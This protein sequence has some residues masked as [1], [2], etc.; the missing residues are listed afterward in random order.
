MARLARSLLSLL[1]LALSSCGSRS[2]FP[3]VPPAPGAA[4]PELVRETAQ[5]LE[6]DLTRSLLAGLAARDPELVA[7]AF[8]PG[9]LARLPGP[10]DG[11]LVA[12]PHFA[13][14][15]YET[16]VPHVSRRGKIVQRLLEHLGPW[17]AVE[18]AELTCS[19]LSLPAGG[20]GATWLALEL[21]LTG[22]RADG[23]PE[24]L[25]LAGVATARREDDR[26]CLERWDVQSGARVAGGATAF[27][28]VS[29]EVGFALSDDPALAALRR[30][31]AER[32]PGQAR[33][34]LSAVDDDG[35]GF[36]D[37]LV[38][39]A[40]EAALL[41]ANDG[42]GGFVPRPFTSAGPSTWGSLLLEV[43]LD[44]DGSVERLPSRVAGYEGGSAW[45]D[46][47][48]R[49]DG[50]WTR[51]ARALELAQPPG[52]RGLAVTAI[53]PLDAD[54]DGRLDLFLATR[55]PLLAVEGHSARYLGSENH[56]LLQRAP[57]EFRDESRERGIEGRR[58]SFVAR[59][60]DFDGDG[61]PDLLE[62]ND[63]EPTVLWRNDGGGRFHADEELG[64]GGLAVRARGASLADIDGSGRW[65]LCLSDRAGPH[66]RFA[67]AEHGSLLALQERAGGPW[68]AR[69]LAA[70]DAFAPLFWDPD[71]D[72]DRD[73]FVATG[74]G[75]RAAALGE[76][77]EAPGE[78]DLL[79]C[80]VGDDAELVD[81]CELV[82][83]DAPR[84][85][86]CA[87]P[88]DVDGDGDLDLALALRDEL[89][90]FENTSPARHFL[91]VRALATRTHAG[92]LGAVV[93]VRAAGEVRR[94]VV[95]ITDGFQT[96]VPSDLHFGLGGATAVEQVEIRWPSGAV[97]RF[98]DVP[99]DR[100]VTFVEGRAEVSAEAVPHWPMASRPRGS[101]PV[102]DRFLPRP[103]GGSGV[104]APSRRPAVVRLAPSLEARE[105]LAVVAARR[106]ASAAIV[107]PPGP[108]D[109]APAEGIGVFVAD[110][111]LLREAF[112]GGVATWPATVVV[113]PRGRVA[114]VFRRPTSIA[115]IEAVLDRLEAGRSYPDLA[116]EAGDD[117]LARGDFA[118]AEREF[119]QA[120]GQDPDQASAYV[121]LARAY[122]AQDRLEMA[123]D[124]CLHALG[125]DAGLARA[126]HE[127]GRARARLGRHAEAVEAFEAARGLG[128]DPTTNLPAL[129]DAAY[130]ARDYG[131]ALDT[132]RAVA[133]LLP[134]DVTRSLDVARLLLQ[135]RRFSEALDAYERALALD[136]D[137]VEAQRGREQARRAL[138]MEGAGR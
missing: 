49:S 123:E 96:Q 109:L 82:G 37:L 70:A 17:T 21:F 33:I 40:G 65:A 118:E 24:D 116:V 6:R 10:Q 15:R 44:G 25:R 48:T 103:G 30:S 85:T 55:G 27:R 105:E 59:A 75:A 127:L 74:R 113:D 64:L 12:D 35:D 31:S 128:F 125:A 110:E 95:R 101:V 26:W 23:R 13:A 115:E 91:R 134:E 100:R 38:T 102:L 137:S 129:A 32:E 2:P 88:V 16:P 68:V 99:V 67:Q 122:L 132:Y 50:V 93:E 45:L 42:A 84:D 57:L 90:L 56:L 5:Q 80:R 87:L 62:G 121:G 79:L 72:G 138:E 86:R 97:E 112:A 106:G 47:F 107:L 52:E 7:R 46:L 58:V 133:A 11:R 119:L 9:V 36:W 60:F 81:L 98:E 29:L 14:R 111:R 83:L 4:D 3:L 120:I 136:P 8:T 39:R 124:A 76:A 22:A 66:E 34:G 69:R 18:R 77:D 41:F 43:D 61:D 94:D 126:H 108:A 54:G 73:L 28:D 117:A 51:R 71:G 1:A 131:R 92:A 20:A 114:R 104:P 135:L 53:A 89:R 78:R 63:P 130:L 19:R